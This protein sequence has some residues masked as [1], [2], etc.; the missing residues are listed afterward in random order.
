MNG[1]AGSVVVE[2]NGL[3]GGSGTFSGA[4][5][6]NRGSLLNPGNSPGTL[7]AN[8]SIWEA[9]STYNWEIDQARDGTAGEN[10]DVF[11]VVNALD[12]KGLSS[13]AKMNLVL[14]SLPSMDDYSATS[15][16][17]WVFAQ[18]GSLVGAGGVE[19]AAFTAGANVTDL[20]NIDATA[21]NSGTGPA[22]G[23]RVQVGDTGNTLNLMA[24]P[25][26]ST[27][28]MLGLGLA[29]LVVTRLLRRKT[30]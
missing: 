10:W 11:S 20:F 13:T 12:L 30:S 15:Q 18:A 2:T 1:T 9:G 3:V 4:V 17:S 14:N 6:L 22:N 8:S 7:T 28:S 19:G 26:P 23:W 16:Y 25:E 29:G 21:F 24:V 27:G 5:T